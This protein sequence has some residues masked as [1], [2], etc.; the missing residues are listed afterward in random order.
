M[1]YRK[2]NRE[3]SLLRIFLSE[4]DKYHHH[5]LY[6]LIMN[7]A[8]EA[9][10]AGCTVFRGFWGYGARGYVHTDI[11]LEGAGERPILIE[12]VDEQVRV[13][14]FARNVIPILNKAGGL[15]TEVAVLV[16]HYQH[17]HVPSSQAETINNFQDTEDTKMAA[18]QREL[19]GQNVLLRIFIGALDKYDHKPL[20]EVILESCKGHGIA[21]CTVI[22]GIMGF[23]ASSV[24][25]KGHLLRL[26]Q[27]V[28]VLLEVVDTEDKIQILLTQ[29]KPML[30]GALV[31]EEKVI[32]H[33]HATGTAPPKEG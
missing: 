8:R 6:V 7:L 1:T 12:I 32:I 2:L 10:L 28:P 22:Q 4:W 13:Q 11:G 23:G 14:E 25:H 26:S 21:G 5:T 3:S 15:V 16:N 24:I 27:D 9:G 33:H 20:F 30:Q 31:T 19:M 17:Q 18:I 29:I